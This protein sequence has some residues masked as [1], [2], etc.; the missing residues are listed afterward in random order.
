M[1]S[2]V[3]VRFGV[4]GAL[5]AEADGREIA[6]GGPRQRSV[7]ATLLIARGAVV[8]AERIVSQVWEGARTPSPTTLH[9]YVSELR[10]ALEPRRAA[11]TPAGLLVR[12]GPGYALR[13]DPAAVDSER[14]ADLAARGRLALDAGEPGTAQELLGRALALWRGPAYADLAAAGF[15][16]PEAARLEELRAAAREDRLAAAVGSGQHRAAVADL[17]TLVTDEPLRERGW[18]LLVL[19]LYRSGRQADALASLRAVRAR[20][21][22]ELGIDPGP[23]LRDLESAVLAQ[24]PRLEPPAA[25]LR[26]GAAPSPGPAERTG[27]TGITRAVEPAGNLPFALSRFVGRTADMS[28]VG[29]LLREHRLVTLTG[30]GGVGKTRLALETARCRGDG[31]GP[32]LVELAQLTSPELLVATVADAVGVPGTGSADQLAAV[33]TD[34]ELLLVLDNCE[35]LLAPVAS[36][37]A[38]LLARCGG[39]RVLATSREVLGVDGEAVYEVVPLD[40]AGDGR[41]L[42]LSRAAT[43]LPAWS[44]GPR[45][46][47]RVTG[48]CA[49]LDGIPL[50]IELAAAQ[51][52]VLSVDQIADALH[53]R[54]EVLVGGL[55]DAPERHRTIEATVAWSHRLLDAPE[56]RLFHRL[57]VFAAGFDIDAAAAVGGLTPVLPP[58]SA[59]VRKSLLAVE[60]GTAPRRYRMLETLRQYA[61]REIDPGDLAEAGECH[62]AWALARA[63]RTERLLHGPR[64]AAEL[65]G[66]SRDQPEFRAAFASALTAGDGEYALRLGGALHWFWYRMGHITEGL[67]RMDD[68]FAAAP[69][70]DPAV[71]CRARL[72]VGA[73]SYLAGRPDRAY[74]AVLLAE[75]EAG[76]AGDLV[77]LTSARTYRTHLGVLAGR[78]VDAPALARDALASARRTGQDWLVA[79]ALMMQ[80][81]LARVT[82]DLGSAARLLSEA[83]TVAESCGHDWAAGSSAWTG[84][85]TACDRGD[86]D[87]ALDIAAGILAALDRHDDITSRLVLFHTAAHA[88]A[89]TGRAEQGATVLGAVRS[90]GRRIG[91]SPELMDP[92]DGPREAAAVRDALPPAVYARCA[93]EG[94]GLSL[95]QL[96]DR[97]TALLATRAGH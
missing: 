57:A 3:D 53:D 91:F 60:P 86:G 83:I 9:A 18:E 31:D 10:R 30:P 39:L 2:V 51:C 15:A 23:A 93:D 33:L 78:P 12:E 8:S 22:D 87:G 95:A 79:E 61:L 38:S 72:A 77:V 37:V 82:G 25:P 50:A 81:M 58:L 4:L 5:R 20:L 96:T 40:P 90:I 94:G 76:Q 6:L 84:M 17:E 29:E 36:L 70:A 54:F 68:A 7:L 13:I 69:D 63:E 65:A 11:R 75:Q 64:A 80:G 34:C 26:S 73:L 42:F 92:L 41:E 21:A 14:F 27:G 49:A 32:W 44:P 48:V 56:R 19:A 46:L 55:A 52:R 1:G 67:A 89:L 71:R 85:K 88:L 24:D 74:D 16:A 59:L 28:R 43:A 45:E 97:L 66:L 62:R 47:D 35:H